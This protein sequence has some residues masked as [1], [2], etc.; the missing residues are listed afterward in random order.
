MVQ[1]ALERRQNPRV[2]TRLPV[3]LY[4]HGGARVIETLTKDIASEGLRC[5]SPVAAPVSMEFSVEFTTGP[6]QEP[7]TVRGR[8]AWFRTIPESDQFDLGIRFLDISPQTSRRL[9]SYLDHFLR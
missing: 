4:Q 1:Q 9:S 8:T 3:R 2:R 5:V 7:R 6:G